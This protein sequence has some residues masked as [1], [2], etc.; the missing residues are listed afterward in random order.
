MSFFEIILMAIG[1]SMDAFA[2]SI[3][4]GLALPKIKV[5]HICLAGL[6]FG[7]FQALM[8]LIGFFLGSHFS[9]VIENFDHWIAFALLAF[10]GFNM[11]RESFS[12]DSKISPDFSPWPMLILA[13]ATSIDALAA[14][15]SF[16]ILH[17]NIWGTCCI[18]GCTTFLF[19]AIGVALGVK[20]GS[21]CKTIAERL[22]GVILISLGA[23]I[24]L[25]HLG[26]F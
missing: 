15:V 19:S 1:L 12:E 24:L 11:L 7:A 5:K 10:I 26:L 14:G 2:V 8:P 17:V 4:K 3:A 16:A 20:L 22:G 18:I 23:K 21:H 6:Y 13:V 9:K 25:E